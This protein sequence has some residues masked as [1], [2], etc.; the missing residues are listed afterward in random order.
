MRQIGG[1]ALLR[2]EVKMGTRCNAYDLAALLRLT[3]GL[4]EV[5]QTTAS[6][7]Y[8]EVRLDVIDIIE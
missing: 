4:E 1:C 6:A 2:I 8:G 5:I 3:T 7:H